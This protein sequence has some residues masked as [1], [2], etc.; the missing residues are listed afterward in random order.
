MI[1]YFK[2]NNEIFIYILI[3]FV[4]YKSLFLYGDFVRDDWAIKA[5]HDL[6]F[7]DALT[8]IYP[9]FSNRPITGIFFS[10]TSRISGSFLFYLILN[11]FFIII[12]SYIIFVSLNF[13]KIFNKFKILFIF[14]TL[15]PLFSYSVI[16][17]SGMQITGNLSVFLWSISFYFHTKFI[18]S[19]KVSKLILSNFVLLLMLL[20]YES[21]LPLLALNI[22]TIFF[23]KKKYIFKYFLFLISAIIFGIIIQKLVLASFYPDISRLRIEDLNINKLIFYFLGNIILLI[24]NFYLLFQNFVPSIKE[25]IYNHILL[26]DYL[27]LLFLIIFLLKKNFKIDYEIVQIKLIYSFA[28]SSLVLCLLFVVFIHSMAISGSNI[29]GYNNRALVSLSYIIPIFIILIGQV[30]K[31]KTFKNILIFYIILVFT[32]YI[33]ILDKNI[34]YVKNRNNTVEKIISNFKHSNQKKNYLIYIDDY[35]NDDKFYNYFTF[36]NDNFDFRHQ[37]PSLSNDT[38][39][40]TSLNLNKYCNKVYWDSYFNEYIIKWFI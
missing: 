38:L 2:K 30:I 14:L 7:V 33:L 39:M 31:P 26:I 23:F 36:V 9:P 35:K 19:N 8:Q 40:G 3:F 34:D 20:T 37:L 17:S 5:L 22:T 32:N 6:P 24:N 28:I 29:Y 21:A 12:S 10:F 16:L 1:N 18:N 4:C 15:F 13:L 27:I 25:I 11:F